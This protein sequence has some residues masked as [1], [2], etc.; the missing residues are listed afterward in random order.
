MTPIGP[1]CL[2]E[3]EVHFHRMETFHRKLVEMIV[4]GQSPLGTTKDGV[5]VVHLIPHSAV[6][7]RIRFD[8]AKLIQAGNAISAFGDDG[9]Y[10][11]SRFNVDGLLLLDSEREPLSWT[12]IFRS[13]VVE[14]ASSA[15]TF[16][17]ADPYSRNKPDDSPAQQYLRDDACEKA[18]IQL[19]GDYC[20]FC[21]TVGVVAPFTMFSALVGCQGVRIHSH[22]G[23]SV[24]LRSV[25]RSPAFLPEIEFEGF[26]FDPMSQLQ[27]WCDTLFQAI[28]FE[29]SPNFDETGKWSE[30]RR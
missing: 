17:V 9:R 4:N 23:Y 15:I 16:S 12:Q 29:R 19:V 22:R 20:K 1:F 26:D 7:T 10:G 2:S 6:S 25:D 24:S 21:N 27:P 5:L 18:V 3:D 11:T 30:R 28:G 13:G 14:A 8:G